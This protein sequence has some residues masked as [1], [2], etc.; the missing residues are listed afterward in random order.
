MSGT[1][2]ALDR[3]LLGGGLGTSI[4]SRLADDADGAPLSLALGRPAWPYA[5]AAIARTTGRPLLLVT[6]DDDEARDLHAELMVLMGRG[7][8]ALWPTRGVAPGA[9]VGASPH[10]LGQRAR[11][12]GTLGR[13]GTVVVVSAAALAESVPSADWPP[14]SSWPSATS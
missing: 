12:L 3:L 14:S 1:G 11:A 7:S 5:G 9:A 4:A 2:T 6:P 8:T 10:L 13:E